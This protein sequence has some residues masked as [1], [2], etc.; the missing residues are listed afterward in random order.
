MRWMLAEQRRLEETTTVA[1][2]PARV[3]AWLDDPRNP[4]R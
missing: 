1:A 2:P 3:F 4:P